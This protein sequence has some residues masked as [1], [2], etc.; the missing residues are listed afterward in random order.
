MASAAERNWYSSNSNVRS[1]ADAGVSLALSSAALGCFFAGTCSAGLA[2]CGS[3]RLCSGGVVSEG[4]CARVAQQ[5][6]SVA[7]ANPTVRKII[8]NREQC[9]EILRG[10]ESIIALV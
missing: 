8:F 2:C 3:L 9:I 10:Q 4:F 5:I 6:A 7:A 1:M